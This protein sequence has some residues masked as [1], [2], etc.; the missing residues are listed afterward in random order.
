VKV[1]EI[2]DGNAV[3]PVK[4]PVSNGA[5]FGDD[6]E[7]S[8]VQ[9]PPGIRHLAIGDEAVVKNV[10]VFEF[11]G[12]RAFEIKRLLG[13]ENSRAGHH[14]SLGIP[15]N[16]IERAALLVI[17]INGAVAIDH[18]VLVIIPVI[19]MSPRGE[20]FGLLVVIG[21]VGAKRGVM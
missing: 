3:K 2:E 10:L 7:R 11:I 4:G 6:V 8:A 20:Y 9:R 14:F 17:V 15:A 21:L 13:G 18:L 19:D 12:V 16:V 1:R 5:V